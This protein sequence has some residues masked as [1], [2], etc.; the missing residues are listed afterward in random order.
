[1]T[2][3]H[4]KFCRLSENA[5]IPTKG[6]KYSAGYDLRAAMDFILLPVPNLNSSVPTDICVIIPEGYYGRIAPRS[7][8]ALN[9]ID[10]GAG[11]VDRDYRG[12]LSVVMYNYGKHPFRIKKGERI[13]QLICEKIGEFEMNEITLKEFKDEKTER[14]SGG[15]GST[16]KN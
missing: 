16:G 3:D 15:F 5:S 4:I 10:V 9:M 12:P 13:A 2:M 1:M 8:L 6:S 11:V 14:G 7:G